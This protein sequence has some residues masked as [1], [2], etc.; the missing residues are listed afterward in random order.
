MEACFKKHWYFSLFLCSVDLRL[1]DGSEDGLKIIV[2]HPAEKW[3]QPYSWMC[4]YINIRVTIT[5]ICMTRPCIQGSWV[6]MRRI[7]IQKPQ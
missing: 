2:I 1:G 4:V 5:M 6:P 3:Q 7:S